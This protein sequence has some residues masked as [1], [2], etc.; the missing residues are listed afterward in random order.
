MSRQQ[1]GI[2]LVAGAFGIVGSAVVDHLISRSR[3]VIGLSRRSPP[4]ASP[5]RFISVDLSR[6]DDCRNRLTGLA[7]V[8]HLVYAALSEKHDIVAGWTAADQMQVNLTMLGNLLATLETAAPA[9][10]RVVLLQGAKAYGT[11]VARMRIPGKESQPRHCHENFYWLQED[12]LRTRAAQAQWT[13]TIIRP[14]AVF[15]WALGGQMNVIAAIGALAAIARARREVFTFPG[16]SLAIKEATD[17]SL[18]AK[19]ITWACDAPESANQIFNITNGDS[20]TWHDLW[21]VFADYYSVPFGGI[22]ARSLTDDISQHSEIWA[23][24]TQAH[25]LRYNLDEIA[26]PSGWRF[27][28]YLLSGHEGGRWPTVLSTIKARQFGFTECLDTEENVHYWLNRLERERIL[29]P[30][31]FV[32][33]VGAALPSSTRRVQ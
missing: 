2:V 24:L 10:Q 21:S 20:F 6:V 32:P 31:Q 33:P 9:L 15:G 26:G 3:P 1:T 23:E 19:A 25:S 11:H 22:Q 7:D 14:Q 17:S 18:L 5:A 28:D 16:D 8:S 12:L 13:W 29:P 27:L 4:A 30:A